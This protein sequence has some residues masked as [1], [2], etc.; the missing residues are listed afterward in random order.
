MKSAD[1]DHLIHRLLGQTPP[2]VWSLLVTMFGDLALAP[3]A[4][5]SG[6]CVNALTAAIGIKPEATRVALHRLRKEG[7][8]ESQ[9]VGRQSRYGLTN[10]GRSETQAA[11]PRVYA[12]GSPDTYPVVALDDPSTAMVAEDKGLGHTTVRI[13]PHCVVTLDTARADTD[14]VLTMTPSDR[15]PN[16]VAEKLCPTEVQTASAAL[17]TR[18]RS[19]VDTHE[20]AALTVLQRTALRV[21]VV[22][23]WRRLIL[24]VPDFPDHLFSEGWRGPACRGLLHDLLTALP[25]PNLS[26]LEDHL[27]DT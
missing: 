18:F 1:F 16:W 25:A 6:A 15:V 9:R 10:L 3:D 17:E 27:G 24:R 11:R 23:E 21:S 5:L 8:I 26:D 13:G 2:R 14:L 22:H 12:T 7:W 19:L 4:R 20:L